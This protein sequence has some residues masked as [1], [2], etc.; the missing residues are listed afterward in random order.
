VAIGGSALAHGA[1]IGVGLA[2]LA[3][4]P[5]KPIALVSQVELPKYRFE[6]LHLRMPGMPVL[7]PRKHEA[8]VA[9]HI[10]GKI[11]R[12]LPSARTPVFD[13][14]PPDLK[15]KQIATG[16]L[17]NDWTIQP[18]QSAQPR[19]DEVAAAREE[20]A[21]TNQPQTGGAAT[22]NAGIE[23][24]ATEIGSEDPTTARIELPR[25]GKPSMTILGESVAEQY[26]E[27]AGQM[28]GRVVSSIY[29]RMGLKKSWILEYWTTA[30]AD[31]PQQKGRTSMPDAPWP[32]VMMR[33]NLSIP[34]GAEALF[35][36]GVV[37]VD[38]ELEQLALLPATDWP[39]R[40]SLFQALERWKIRPA[41]KDGQAQAVE[42]LLIIPRQPEQE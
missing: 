6:V 14:S 1:L 18:P 41:S 25:N 24:P 19:L 32:W 11:A 22:S 42:V 34:S 26:P 38:G 8:S 2:Y 27:T 13:D 17:L 15:F 23:G 28:H 36:R 33:P 37:T 3:A 39:Q 30:E 10:S 35:V 29:L 4:M 16:P 12:R 5:I 20:P 21:S 40:N 31:S 7:G 9:R